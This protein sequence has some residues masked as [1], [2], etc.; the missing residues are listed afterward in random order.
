NAINRRLAGLTPLNVHV[1]VVADQPGFPADL[2]HYGVAG[3][4]AQAALDAIEL[5]AVAD[6]N[7]SRA[8]GDTLIAID[9][10][11]DRLSTRSQFVR[12]LQRGPLF[13]AL[14]LVG[15][16][17]RPF[18]SQCG[19]DA[20]PRAHVHANLLAH[21][22]GEHISRRREDRDPDIGKRRRLEGDQLLHQ[23]W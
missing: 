4:D 12:L 18:V 16:V 5:R 9:A 8:D 2:F 13:T 22:T 10:V 23:R 15:D 11:A 7:A 6:V 21:E 14:V 17:K 3:I 19:L 20:R 1:I